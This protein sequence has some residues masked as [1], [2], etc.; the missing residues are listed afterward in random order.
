MFGTPLSVFSRPR[1]LSQRF[2]EMN[3]LPSEKWFT[4][5][6]QLFWHLPQFVSVVW[7]VRVSISSKES[8][9][10]GTLSS[11]RSLAIRAAP[12][13]PMMPAISGRITWPSA[14]FS[15]ARRTA[16]L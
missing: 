14:I 13:A 4:V 1:P 12:K 5:R 6:R 10:V 2:P 8:M 11:Y 15:R 16:S 3:C 7:K 9:V